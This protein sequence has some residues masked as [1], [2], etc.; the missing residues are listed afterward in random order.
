MPDACPHRNINKDLG[1]NLNLNLN[2]SPRKFNRCR[3]LKLDLNLNCNPNLGLTPISIPTSAPPP[4]NIDHD[5][6]L[7]LNLT[8]HLNLKPISTSTPPQ[9][10][11]ESP[12]LSQS[13]SQP[14]HH[15]NPTLNLNFLVNL[16]HTSP[17]I[18]AS[19]PCRSET[20]RT[21]PKRILIPSLLSL[22]SMLCHRCK[23]C[24]WHTHSLRCRCCSTSV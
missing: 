6:G 3:S 17:S 7:D 14:S 23:D 12:L 8:R 10:Q 11:S 1:P 5:L 2:F 24:M 22:Q 16:S 9:L 21:I 20:A 19:N 4:C 15:P 18:S 13:P